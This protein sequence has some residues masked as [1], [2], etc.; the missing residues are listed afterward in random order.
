MFH[1]VPVSVIAVALLAAACGKGSDAAPAAGAPAQASAAGAASNSGQSAVSD[2]TSM[3]NVVRVAVGSK[4]H[5]TLVA[6]LQAAG[7]VDPLASPGPFT[8]FA[9]TNAA[10]DKL[11][12]G[13]VETLLKPEN[14]QQLVDI[15]Q[16]H[17]TTSALDV[18]SF[19][20]GQDLGLVSAGSEKITKKDGATYIGGAKIV[21]SVRASNGWVHI[22]DAV[23]VP[24]AK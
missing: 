20:D 14:K 2:T 5:T 11:P 12:K 8:V 10:F 16:H 18:A 9:P 15:L 4:D 24:K 17:V 3:P 7:L 22:I 1:R 23:L 6:A 19:T 21:A 13:T